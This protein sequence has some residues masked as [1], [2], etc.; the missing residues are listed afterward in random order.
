MVHCIKSV[1]FRDEVMS[2]SFYPFCLCVCAPT[3]RIVMFYTSLRN[4]K[5]IRDA[6]DKESTWKQ[7]GNDRH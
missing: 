2:F 3:H 1:D 5:D 6:E 7:H 4:L